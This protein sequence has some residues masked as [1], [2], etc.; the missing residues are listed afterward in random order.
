MFAAPVGSATGAKPRE[1]ASGD[2]NG[3]GKLD[4]AVANSVGNSVSILL[5][6]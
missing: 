3:D 2:V 4:V 5:A 1:I 6:R